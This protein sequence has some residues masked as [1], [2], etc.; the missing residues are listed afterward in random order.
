MLQVVH[1]PHSSHLGHS[2]TC[3]RRVLIWWWNDTASHNGMPLMV[4]TTIIK[5]S[6]GG[7]QSLMHTCTFRAG[8]RYKP[9][10]PTPATGAS[11]ATCV[12]HHCG[13]E[14]DQY[15]FDARGGAGPL[16]LAATL[17]MALIFII[18]AREAPRRP[19]DRSIIHLN[20]IS[21]K[22]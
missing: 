8:E 12:C 13:S 18:P 19:P 2:R 15:P 1:S 22:V 3:A 5:R 6:S 20:E 10:P 4:W 11:Q 7:W 17:D 9:D 21:S 16:T 14:I